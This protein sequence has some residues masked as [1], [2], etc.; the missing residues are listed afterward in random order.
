MTDTT[1]DATPVDNTGDEGAS[2]DAPAEPTDT[3]EVADDTPDAESRYERPSHH[4]QTLARLRLPPSRLCVW[5]GVATKPVQTE[6][7]PIVSGR[8]LA[9]LFV[10]FS[11]LRCT[12]LFV[13]CYTNPSARRQGNPLSPRAAWCSRAVMVGGFETRPYLF[14]FDCPV[15]HRV[16]TENPRAFSSVLDNMAAPVGIS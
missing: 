3:P 7:S 5:H 8:S 16:T 13:V 15:S 11:L 4:P 1:N 9:H 10:P 2:N 14:R 12:T 6:R